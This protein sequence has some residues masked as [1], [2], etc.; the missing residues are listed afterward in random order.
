MSTDRKYGNMEVLDHWHQVH[1]LVVV[2]C[3]TCWF[4]QALRS[5]WWGLIKLRIRIKQEAEWIASHLPRTALSRYAKR[6]YFWG[7]KWLCGKQCF[8]HLYQVMYSKYGNHY[9][10][11]YLL[12]KWVHYYPHED[13]LIQ[14]PEAPSK[15]T[16][17]RL[18]VQRHLFLAWL[19]WEDLKSHLTV[20]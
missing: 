15:P 5:D 11:L 2:Q 9:F 20:K 16:G 17:R 19:A 1:V 18:E 3:L 10:L 8:L 7:K 14:V 4:Q 6:T 12:S 13:V